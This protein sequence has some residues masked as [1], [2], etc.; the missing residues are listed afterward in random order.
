MH[1]WLSFLAGALFL[2][3]GL[4]IF[5]IEIYGVYRFDF[6]LNRMHMAALGD[7][8]GL[9][10]SLIGLAIMNG[11]SFATL[12][13]I[14]VLAFLWCASPVSSHMISRLEVNTNEE[15][16]RH[17]D[18]GNASLGE[19]TDMGNARLGEGMDT[20]NAGLGERTDMGNARLGEHTDM[21]NAGSDTGMATTKEA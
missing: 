12:K 7:T 13:I 5:G 4:V 9:G 18:I 19:H 21:E 1:E 14:L 10:L 2:L 3:A 17:V 6:V 11:L 16:A 20:V 8:L 15:L